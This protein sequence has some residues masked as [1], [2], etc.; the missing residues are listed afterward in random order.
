MIGALGWCVTI[1]INI[2]IYIV[3]NRFLGE[4][5]SNIKF[6]RKSLIAIFLSAILTDILIHT[7]IVFQSSYSEMMMW[8]S[9]SFPLVGL[10][11][12]IVNF[13]VKAIS[14]SKF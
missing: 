11:L 2:V 3:L 8:S 12:I 1:F 7:I 5:F 4:R 10:C 6:S 13:I 9:I 14:E